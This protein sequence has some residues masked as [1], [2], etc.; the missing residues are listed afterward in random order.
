MSCKAFL[1]SNYKQMQHSHTFILSRHVLYMFAL[2]SLLVFTRLVQPFLLSQHFLLWRSFRKQQYLQEASVRHLPLFFVAFTFTLLGFC[3]SGIFSFAM[4]C[5]LHIYIIMDLYLFLAAP[6]LLQCVHSGR[7]Q[8]DYIPATLLGL[9]LLAELQ[10]A[11]VYF[12]V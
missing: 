7:Q 3:I 11:T 12:T 2:D 4:Q 6:F 5:V 8:P 10:C 1:P 9:V